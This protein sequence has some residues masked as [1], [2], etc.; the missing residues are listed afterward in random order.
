MNG[1]GP[2]GAV[3]KASRVELARAIARDPAFYTANYLHGHRRT[4][5]G[6]RQRFLRGT[7]F[8]H[9]NSSAKPAKKPAS[10]LTLMARLRQ[11][12]NSR[13]PAHPSG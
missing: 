1:G 9:R 4:I 11:L 10:G 3:Q 6:A 7:S 13:K 12:R 5:Q 8:L 2:A